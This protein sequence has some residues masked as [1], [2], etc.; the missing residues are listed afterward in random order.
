MAVVGGPGER[1]E[2]AVWSPLEYACH[3]RDVFEL[4]CVR[5]ACSADAPRFANW[6]QGHRGRLRLA[7][8]GCWSGSWRSPGQVAGLR[9]DG[10]AFTVDSFTRYL[11]H[12]PV[13]H[14]T[15]VTGVRWA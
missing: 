3:V 13:H 7:G 11:I 14:L 8:S 1:P 6:D 4:A 15:D 10:A 9:G 2:P 12:D 5:C